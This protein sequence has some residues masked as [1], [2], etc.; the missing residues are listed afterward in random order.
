VIDLHCHV[1]PGIDDGPQTIDDSVAL[2]RAGAAAGIC[3]FVA[4]PHVSPRYPNTAQDIARLAE[5]V[6]ERFSAEGLDVDLRTGAEVAMTRVGDTTA[7][8]LRRL[9]L[10]GGPW[11]LVEPPFAP[12]AGGLDLIVR[13]LQR[14]GHR[15]LL[16]HPERCPAL[17]GDPGLVESFI[18]DGV[19]MS[20]TA[21]SLVGRFGERVRTFALRLAQEGMIHNVASDAH[22][23]A[24]RSPGMAREIEQCG[25]APL[26][27]WLT[28]DVPAAILGGSTT[29]PARP[30]VE[31][32]DLPAR[33][34]PRWRRRGR[35]D[36]GQAG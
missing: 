23:T 3:T 22:D 5:Q 27:A 16:A 30:D 36:A 28:E 20:V 2:A 25:L 15:I 18:A 31:L 6:R 10:G 29:I 11:L 35:G 33:V 7:E 24:G 13:E 21:G 19:L 32:P 8:E 17:H 14:Q 4:T 12:G 26:R 1:L 9:R 34:R